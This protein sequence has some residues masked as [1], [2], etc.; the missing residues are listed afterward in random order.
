MQGRGALY[1]PTPILHGSK[2]YMEAS[3]ISMASKSSINP[4]FAIFRVVI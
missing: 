2:M 1:T 4:A 3:S